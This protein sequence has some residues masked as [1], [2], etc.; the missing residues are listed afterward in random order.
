M[1]MN[2]LHYELELTGMRV[3][4]SLGSIQSIRAAIEM[5][6]E[7]TRFHAAQLWELLAVCG[8]WVWCWSRNLS[9]MQSAR[10]A[11]HPLQVPGVSQSQARTRQ[12]R[13]NIAQVQGN[14]GLL[15][16]RPPD[17]WQSVCSGNSAGR[18]L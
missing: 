14:V 18:G 17:L 8:F 1:V 10:E 3:S 7:F 9:G 5:L 6:K 15:Y 16:F 13:G 2:V 4:V 11:R 12:R